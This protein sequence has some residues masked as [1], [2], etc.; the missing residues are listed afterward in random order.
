MS[1][2]ISAHRTAISPRPP[3]LRI[4]AAFCRAFLSGLALLTGSMIVLT[5]AAPAFAEL[6]SEALVRHI[7]KNIDSG[8]YVGVIVGLV[9]GDNT[10]VQAF[11]TTTKD[12]AHA[13][14]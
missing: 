14:E 13:A 9:D 3:A 8:N 10:Y 2:P 6:P 5:V 4:K 12:A 11:G 1:H 7:D